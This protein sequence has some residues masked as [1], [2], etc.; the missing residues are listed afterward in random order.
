MRRI[1]V[2]AAAMLLFSPPGRAQN[3]RYEAE[4]GSYGG[5]SFQNSTPAIQAPDT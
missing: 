2:I 1:L 5:A 3:Y 4:L